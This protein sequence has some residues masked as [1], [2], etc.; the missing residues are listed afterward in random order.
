MFVKLQ[1]TNTFHQ[2]VWFFTPSLCGQDATCWL[3]SSITYYCHRQCAHL[4]GGLKGRVDRNLRHVPVVD[5]LVAVPHTVDQVSLERKHKSGFE[6]DWHQ[7]QRREITI[8]NKPDLNRMTFIIL[9]WGWWGRQRRPAQRAAGSWSP[10]RG[11]CPC[12]GS[13]AEEEMKYHTINKTFFF[14]CVQ[15]TSSPPR[16]A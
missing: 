4:R 16:T 14:I 15:L 6:M 3:N 11:G 13:P 12:T 1:Q 7:I 5:V 10:E 8:W 2:L 9:P